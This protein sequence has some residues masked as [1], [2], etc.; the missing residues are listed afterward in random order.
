MRHKKFAVFILSHGRADNVKTLHYLKQQGYTG[1]YYIIIDNE[2]ETADEYYSRFGEDHVIMFDKAE[3]A[4]NVDMGDNFEGRNVVVIARNICHDVAK[5]LGLDYFL[6]LDDDYS[7]FYVR[8]VDGDSLNALVIPNLDM[9]FDEMLD[10]LDNSGAVTVAFAQ[11][12]DYIGGAKS[13]QL[14]KGMLRKE[15]NA[16]FC[17]TDRPFK[18]FGRINEDVNA[19]VKLGSEGKL[20]FT[21]THIGLVQGQTQQNAGGL[22]DAY[23]D[24]GTYVKSFYS[25]MYCPSC[26]KIGMMGDK[27]YRLHHNV[28]WNNAVPLIIDE[29]WK[30]GD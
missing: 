28:M 13:S 22:T 24:L 6:E 29:K 18:F 8:Y 1:N 27:D 9:V 19:Y 25:V 30:K 7:G 10:F 15:M 20:F 21:L 11:A 2:D 12:G 26:V 23:L 4:K 16:F 3:A 14:Q 17:R 5:Q